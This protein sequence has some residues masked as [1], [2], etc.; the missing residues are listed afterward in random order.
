MVASSYNSGNIGAVAPSLATKLGDD[1]MYYILRATTNFHAQR[2]THRAK[3]TPN[4]FTT[5]ALHPGCDA[6]RVALSE[7]PILSHDSRSVHDA[8]SVH[9]LSYKSPPSCV[10]THTTHNKQHIAFRTIIYV[11]WILK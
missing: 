3:V 4:G 9:V 11:L 7:S 6:R 10:M 1:Y 2:R 5:N 8:R